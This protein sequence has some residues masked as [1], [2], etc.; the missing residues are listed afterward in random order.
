LNDLRARARRFVDEELIPH[1]RELSQ[2]V[3][4]P[5]EWRARLEHAARAAG[6]WNINTPAEYGGPGL[7]MRGR[8]AIWEELGRTIALPPRNR[9]VMGPEV[10]PILFHLD[11]EQRREYL[12]PVLRGEKI[13]CFAQTEPDA[14]GDPAAM[15]T[16]ARREGDAYVIDG[17]K[18]LIGFV[19]E[20][21]F[22]QLF[23]TTDLSKGV[24]GISAFL[25]PIGTPGVRIVR[26]MTTMMRDRPFELSFENVRIPAALRIG[27]EG[28]GFA[29]AQAWITE[30]RLLRHAARGIGVIERCLELATAYA[31]RRS[32]F[33]SPLAER[34]S[35]QWMIV[36][37]YVSLRQLRQMTYD[38][39]ERYDRGEDVRFDSYIC[40][41]TGD[42]AAFAATDRCLQIYGGIGL[43]TDYP[44]ETMWRDQRS[45]VITEGPTEILK[46]ALF[47]HVFEAYSP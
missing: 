14:G 16:T 9:C 6:L 39:A 28:R 27:D 34:Q 13:A 15:T 29:Y 38:V 25:V 43:T 41:F 33:G 22:I 35:I 37:M 11:A 4:L 26:Q 46:S 31:A 19:D 32:T 2:W 18:H 12:E 7:G 3:A 23:A 20:A 17:R 47:R 42:E 36:D 40:K 30:G 1:E 8:V 45:F 10:S 24:R 21:D 44:I 5:A